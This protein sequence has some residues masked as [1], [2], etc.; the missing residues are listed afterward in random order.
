MSSERRNCIPWDEWDEMSARLLHC[1][2]NPM[3]AWCTADPEY[4]S[5]QCPAHYQHAV[6]AKL[7][8]VNARAERAEFT[9]RFGTP[10]DPTGAKTGTEILGLRASLAKAERERDEAREMSRTG[11]ALREHNRARKAERER[12]EH[13]QAAFEMSADLERERA[14]YREAVELM[15]P[16]KDQAEYLAREGI[17][18]H[19]EVRAIARFVEAADKEGGKEGNDG[20]K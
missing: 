5:P 12:D 3:R 8:E 2:S 13:K 20:A 11:D 19:Y 18:I 17:P 15:R 14:K 4:H 16:V 10:F 9:Q 7:R 6:A 1:H